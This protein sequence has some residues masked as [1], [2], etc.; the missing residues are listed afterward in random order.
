MEEFLRDFNEAHDGFNYGLRVVADG[1]YLGV[2]EDRES[3]EC[4]KLF[5]FAVDA[6]R[7][8]KCIRSVLGQYGDIP[9]NTDGRTDWY[10]K[11]KRSARIMSSLM[12][13]DISDVQ[14]IDYSL[15]FQAKWGKG[16]DCSSQ[17]FP[18]V[19]KFADKFDLMQREIQVDQLGKPTCQTLREVHRLAPGAYRAAASRWPARSKQLALYSVLNQR[20]EGLV[21][22]SYCR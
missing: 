6:G 20:V 17:P 9:K 14:V 5:A 16:V 13:V 11:T 2:C 4:L 22:T 15:P 1:A 7:Q 12:G 10:G 21:A 8:Y 18:K 3:E 19:D